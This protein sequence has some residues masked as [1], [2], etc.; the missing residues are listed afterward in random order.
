[1]D[2]LISEEVD[3][4]AIRKLAAQYEVVREPDLWRHPAQLQKAIASARAILVRNQTQLTAEILAGAPELIAIGRNGVGLDNIDVPAASKLG[5]VV[6]APLDA[7]A[8]SVAEFTLG[9]ILALARKIPHADRS[10]KA[11]GWDRKS[12]TGIELD[13]KTLAVCG[14]GRIGRK[15]AMMARG[16]GMKIVVFD[17]FIPLASPALRDAGAL[18]TGTLEE[19]LARADIVTAHLPL[20]PQTKQMFNARAFSAMKSGAYFI[21]TSRGGLLEEAA[22][23]QALR[24]GHLG[25]AAL[26][27]RQKE[28]PGDEL[29]FE[30]MANVILTP[31]IASFTTEAQM[32]TGDAVASDLERVLRGEAAVHFVNFPCPAPR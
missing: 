25:G 21:N 17:P 19:S 10:T 3:S 9:L 11:G 32:R 16:F 29:G 30:R 6:I 31:H 1:V 28:P 5:M 18:L 13:G 15:V 8:T 14:F 7:N 4:P 20:T 2:I 27:V 26:D 22:L 24:R 23:A 12:G